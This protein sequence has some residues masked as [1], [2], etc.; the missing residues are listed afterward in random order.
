MIL[1]SLFVQ[2][3]EGSTFSVVPFI[4]KKGIGTGSGIV[5]AGGNAG[6][7]AA[8]FLFKSESISYSDG[9]FYL[10]IVVALTSFTS[11][12]IRFSQVDEKISKE[13]V[14]K[15]ISSKKLQPSPLRVN[16]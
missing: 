6:A 16:A 10:G 13:E 7:V 11:L 15:S 1:F 8:G 4:N 12:F 5:G 2:M 14:N 9:L 3:S